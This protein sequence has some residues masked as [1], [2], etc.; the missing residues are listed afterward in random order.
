MTEN[1]DNVLSFMRSD[2]Q[3]YSHI[4]EFFGDTSRTRSVTEDT[5]IVATAKKKFISRRLVLN[6]DELLSIGNASMKHCK[7]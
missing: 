6:F 5:S 4:D 3:N 7:H 1:Q 2:H